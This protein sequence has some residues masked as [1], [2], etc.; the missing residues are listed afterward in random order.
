[1]I[2]H[3]IQHPE[4]N[5]KGHLIRVDVLAGIAADMAFKGCGLHDDIYHSR[6]ESILDRWYLGL[7]KVDDKREF[8]KAARLVG[9]KIERRLRLSRSFLGT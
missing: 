1:M 8:I 5:I 4:S 7:D 9:Y 2:N 6:L 3:F